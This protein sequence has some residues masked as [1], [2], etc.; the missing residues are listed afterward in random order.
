MRSRYFI[1][2]CPG[3][4]SGVII[5]WKILDFLNI[6]YS[7]VKI[8]PNKYKIVELDDHLGIKYGLNLGCVNCVKWSP[9]GKLLA[10]GGDDNVVMLWKSAI[11]KTVYSDPTSKDSHQESWRCAFNL[12]GHT[13][14]IAWDP[15]G[16]YL[17]S[18]SDDNTLRVWSVSDL[19]Q[20]CVNP[21]NK[22]NIISSSVVTIKRPFKRCTPTTQFLRLDWSPDGQFI[23]CSHALNNGGPVAKIIERDAWSCAR[24]LVGHRKAVTI[25]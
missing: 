19:K 10:S 16:E 13:A 24:D 15:I 17:A 8:P 20:Y 4:Q 14:G 11:I 12:I 23:I 18:Q 1:S 7:S 6:D 5:I 25:V 3:K 2:N 9:D 22:K 21:Q